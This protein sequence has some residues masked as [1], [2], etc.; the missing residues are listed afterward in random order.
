[1]SLQIIALSVIGLLC[2]ASAC[3][4]QTTAQLFDTPFPS[5]YNGHGATIVP[6]RDSSQFHFPTITGHADVQ[7]PLATYLQGFPAVSCGSSSES[8]NISFGFLYTPSVV[9]EESTQDYA[10]HLSILNPFP[11]NITGGSTYTD[12]EIFNVEVDAWLNLRTGIVSALNYSQTGAVYTFNPSYD[13]QIAQELTG[14]ADATVYLTVRYVNPDTFYGVTS[15]GNGKGPMSYYLYPPPA[16]G[17]VGVNDTGTQLKN[18][19][20]WVENV[21]QLQFYGGF[22]AM[23]STLGSSCNAN[24]AG[25]YQLSPLLDY[26]TDILQDVVSDDSSMYSNEHLGQLNA[27]YVQSNSDLTYDIYATLRYS[28]QYLLVDHQILD[29]ALNVTESECILLAKNYTLNTANVKDS[30]PANVWNFCATGICNY[31]FPN[32]TTG[33]SIS[34]YAGSHTAST[35]QFGYSSAVD[36]NEYVQPAY[37]LPPGLGSAGRFNPARP[38]IVNGP[39]GI[40]QTSSSSFMGTRTMSSGLGLG[41]APFAE[42]ALNA[43]HEPSSES[44]P[45]SN[46]G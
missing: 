32:G 26:L 29:P 10:V 18:E 11:N 41:S 27:T 43:P 45:T 35:C 21:E 28:G 2:A 15:D 8:F 46:S 12:Q 22:I 34:P 23:Q 24:T 9:P 4:A 31:T 20:Y 13:G 25:F 38:Y 5:T 14:R 30:P 44:P 6:A 3:M 37:I 33:E 40:I 7:Q 17:S 42:G 19:L 39:T 36:N 16:L 1:M